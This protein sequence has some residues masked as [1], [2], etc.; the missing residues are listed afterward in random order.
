MS[1]VEFRFFKGDMSVEPLKTID[2]N[3]QNLREVRNQKLEEIFATIPFYNGWCGSET[4]MYGIVCDDDSPA[5]NDVKSMKGYKIE[6]HKGKNVIKP[7][8]RYKAGKE[9]DKKLRQCREILNEAPDFS[10]YSLKQLGLSCWVS[11]G[12]NLY[13]AVAG[14]ANGQY[15]AKIPVKGE[16]CDLDDFPKVPDCLVEIKESEFLALQGK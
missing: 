11:Y 16:D 3:W 13:I 8:R 14:I 6:R 15:I 12:T 1:N 10:D 5:L 4:S 7:D 9:L 2:E